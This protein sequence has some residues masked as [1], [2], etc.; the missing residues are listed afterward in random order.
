M[1]AAVAASIIIAAGLFGWLLEGRVSRG[2]WGTRTSRH[3]RAAARSGAAGSSERAA[4][5]TAHKRALETYYGTGAGTDPGVKFSGGLIDFIKAN[6][7]PPLTKQQYELL[8]DGQIPAGQM[9]VSGGRQMGKTAIAA[10]V[11]ATQAAL[12]ADLYGLPP[13]G[14]SPTIASIGAKMLE[15]SGNARPQKPPS[16][17]RPDMP[18]FVELRSSRPA[19]LLE[20]GQWGIVDVL[21]FNHHLPWQPGDIIRN[22]RTQETMAVVAQNGPLEVLVTR[23]I[24]SEP[25]R[26]T[27]PGDRMLIIGQRGTNAAAGLNPYPIFTPAAVASYHKTYGVTIETAPRSLPGLGEGTDIAVSI[28]PVLAWRTFK[29]G[30]DD[31][32]E[33]ALRSVSKNTLW[34]KRQELVA[35]CTHSDAQH[36]LYAKTGHT[37][38][39]PTCTCGIYLTETAKNALAQSNGGTYVLG[40]VRGWG[41]TVVH[42]TGWR[43]EKAYPVGLFVAGLSD[44][45]QELLR[46][47]YAVPVVAASEKRLHSFGDAEKAANVEG[48]LDAGE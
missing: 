45:A 25:A 35:C 40:V 41:R 4:R 31:N 38:P 48:W 11:A 44:R 14:A 20:R 37:S 17:I 16:S 34:P 26:V 19:T 28:E 22:D 15:L 12:M 2:Y 23:G 33:I 1:T 29:L 9:V 43:V 46:N 8:L 6:T 39:E 36:N 18:P 30:N 27:A 47:A 13:A 42:K 32:F 7:A 10:H 3:D 21:E 24:G 5:V